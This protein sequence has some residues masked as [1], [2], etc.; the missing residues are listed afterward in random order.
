[1]YKLILGLLCSLIATMAFSQENQKFS[2]IKIDLRGQDIHDLAELGLECDHGERAPHK[3]LINIF[4]EDEL[5][6]IKEAGFEWK[7]I[8]DDV[9]AYYDIYGTDDH[10]FGK[11]NSRSVLC[12]GVSDEA[13]YDYD[14]PENYVFGS[15]GG[16]LTYDEALVEFDKMAALYPNLITERQTIDTIKTHE[17]RN[18][19]YQVISNNPNN[20]DESKP[21]IYYNSLHHA[22]E[23]NSMSQL[24]FYMW[25]LLENYETNDEVKYLVDHSVMF[26]QPIINPDGY[27][28]NEITNPQG[29]G[30]WRKNRYANELNQKVGVD[31]NRNY[32]FFWAFDNSGSS[33]METS[34]T[35]RGPSAFSE[36]ETQATK[37]LCE[38]NNFQIALNYHT[39]GNLLIHPWGYSDQ[40]TDEDVL[41]KS[42]GRGMNFENDFFLGTGTETVGY[43]V[44]GDSDDYM[45]GEVV[46]KNKIYSLT[47]E[48]GPSFWP[49]ESQIDLINKS[50]VRMNLNAAHLL[51]NY[52]FG[53]EIMGEDFIT[54]HQGTMTFRF[55]KS[56][57]IPGMIDFSVVSETPGVTVSNNSYPG[58]NMNAG[59]LQEFTINYDVAQ[60]FVGENI[61]FTMI[62]DNGIYP[63]RTSISK[64]NL[65][66]TELPAVVYNNSIDGL[67]NFTSNDWGLSDDFVSAPF[68]I[69]DSPDGIYGN[70]SYSEILFL[71]EFDLS[72]ASEVNLKFYTKYVIENDYDYVQILASS[73]GVN[74]TPLCGKYTNAASQY[75]GVEGDPVY[76]SA[77]NEWVLETVCLDDYLGE[78]SVTIKFAL[79]TDNFVAADGFYFDDVSL[80]VK[81][82]IVS[83]QEI[84]LN[85]MSVMPNPSNDYVQLS[86]DAKYFVGDMNYELYDLIGK[87][88]KA[89]DI[90]NPH[91]K[92][93]ISDLS[94]GTY[95]LKLNVGDTLFSTCKLIK[96]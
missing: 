28:W 37:K 10:R 76:D 8:I 29:G 20:F 85:V 61:E 26:F 12:E 17:G 90:S 82:D 53:K 38:N 79:T 59:D 69:T 72:N 32:G 3:H 92:I 68:S 70:N 2:K 57:L 77:Q 86:M 19:Y 40:P 46:E 65:I 51:F 67:E 89:N 81:S 52:G 31:L 54:T 33:P 25:Y 34:Q 83:I 75:Q 6:I 74:Y 35:Y 62:I 56:G 22:R 42:L 7:V 73:D 88:L 49:N 60:D 27:V 36:P 44:N 11:I 63:H 41:F 58:L 71:D 23:P 94:P 13:L 16:Y 9:K 24:V 45:Y 1:M 5:Q 80:E 39:S 48:V 91:Q 96:N 14:T 4:S 87:K 66:G 21:Q 50:T 47:P 43:V 30:L 18:L 55:E 95:V 15:M 64:K 93:D 78:E 84:P